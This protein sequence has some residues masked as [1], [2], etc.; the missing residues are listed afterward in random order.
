MALS[1]LRKKTEKKKRVSMSERM[2]RRQTEQPR[3]S[4]FKSYLPGKV[5]WMPQ[6]WCITSIA[7]PGRKALA[8]HPKMMTTERLSL[9][10]QEDMFR[11]TP[12]QQN[13]F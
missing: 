1:L 4:L 5:N 2:R 9:I 12:G 3:D 10:L 13:S 11:V 6:S 7:K 8:I